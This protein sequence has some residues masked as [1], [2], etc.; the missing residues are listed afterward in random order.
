MQ[1]ENAAGAAATMGVK[2]EPQVARGD[3]SMK[4]LQKS[5]MKMC[6]SRENGGNGGGSASTTANGVHSSDSD[7]DSDSDTGQQEEDTSIDY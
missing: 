2:S 4:D 7:S 6:V 5:Q 1:H 3:E